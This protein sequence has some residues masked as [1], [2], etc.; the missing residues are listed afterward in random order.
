MIKINK[1]SKT[2]KMNSKL[3]FNFIVHPQ[4]FLHPELLLLILPV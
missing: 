4:L 2:I 3:L 1:K